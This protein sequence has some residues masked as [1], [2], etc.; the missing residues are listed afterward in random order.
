MRFSDADRSHQKQTLIDCRELLSKLHREAGS[1]CLRGRRGLVAIE[2]TACVTLRDANLVERICLRHLLLALALPCS[3]AGD[4]LHSGA[5]TLLADIAV[6]ICSEAVVATTN[7]REF[8][9]CRRG[10]GHCFCK[11]REAE[12]DYNTVN[13]NC[14]NANALGNYAIFK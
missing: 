10:S 7:D 4:D 12:S 2:M 5:E 13:S 1:L 8:G 9:F 14:T 11:I 3:L 6:V